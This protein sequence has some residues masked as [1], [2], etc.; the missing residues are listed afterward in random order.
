M[1]APAYHGWHHS[2]IGADPARTEPWRD[3]LN[4]GTA[5]DAGTGYITDDF[6]TSDFVYIALQGST[7]IEPGVTTGWEAYWGIYEAVLLNSWTAIVGEVPPR[8]RLIVGPSS[9]LETIDDRNA[10][11]EIQMAVEGGTLNTAVTR[12]PPG[13]RPSHDLRLPASDEFG[14]FQVFTVKTDGYVIKGIA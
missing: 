9:T 13:Y 11:L 3:I 8:Y 6:A 14:G 10:S 1:T 7:A 2:P 4:P 12:L 5:W